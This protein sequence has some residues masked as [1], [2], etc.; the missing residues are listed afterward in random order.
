MTTWH[1]DGGFNS[2]TYG[3]AF[4]GG[5]DGPNLAQR[6]ALRWLYRELE[7]GFSPRPGERWAP[8]P[9][10]DTVHRKVNS[11]SCPGAKGEAFYRAIALAFAD[12]PSKG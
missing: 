10:A 3:I 7:A 1:C 8:L 6:K 9:T 2:Y 5:T 4:Q 11:T 12:Y